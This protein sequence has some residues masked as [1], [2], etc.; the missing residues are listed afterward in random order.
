MA[1]LAATLIYGQ[2]MTPEMVEQER[3]DK[4]AGVIRHHETTWLEWELP[5]EVERLAEKFIQEQL[6]KFEN[7]CQCEDC[8]ENRKK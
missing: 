7:K 6:E 2:I 8:K 5:L 3:R 1:K 4:K